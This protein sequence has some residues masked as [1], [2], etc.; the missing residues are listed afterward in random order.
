MIPTNNVKLKDSKGGSTRL[1]CVAAGKGVKMLDVINTVSLD[2]TE[3]FH[4]F[5]D[6]TKI[7][8]KGTTSFPI[9]SHGICIE[10]RII[11]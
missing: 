5:M 2:E 7:Y 10:Y 6:R 11:Y 4:Y 1:K 8:V 3:E 9:R